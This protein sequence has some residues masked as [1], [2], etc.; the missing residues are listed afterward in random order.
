LESLWRDLNLG[1]KSIR[2]RDKST[3]LQLSLV[4]VFVY[5]I[6]RC[7][8]M[9]HLKAI[10]VGAGIA[11]LTT[12][13][14]L[15]QAGYTVEIY[16]KVSSLRPAGAGISLWSN[17]VK[18]LNRLGLGEQLASFGGTM[19]RMEYR[20][21]HDEPLSHIDLRP[22]IHQVGQRP[23]PVSRTDLQEMLLNA[24]GREQVQFQMRC[25]DV[26]ETDDTITAIFDNGY[27]ATGD[28]LVGADGIRSRVREYVLGEPIMPRYANYVNWNGI[29]DA[30]PGLCDADN[31]VIYVGQ[32][33]RAS[34]MPIGGDR[35]YYFFGA[36]MAKGTTVEPANRREELAEIFADWP[37][38]VQKLIQSLDP[39]H[40]NRLE[41]HD[42][43]PPKSLAKG[44]AVLIGDAAHATTPTLGQGGCQA[45]EDVEVL[46][47][48]LVT[49]NISVSDALQRYEHERK[50]RTASLVLKARQRTDTIYGK[51]PALTQEWYEQLKQESP[52]AVTGALA[53]VILGGP[54][55]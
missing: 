50:D 16:E 54:M 38:P 10:V 9:Y 15:K 34:M 17:G 14:A 32:G 39:L 3:C 23:Y 46:T 48:Y 11:G 30:Q 18:V 45:V 53:K 26:E 2:L 5:L 27:R 1:D 36:P 28:I 12:A 43:D 42:I 4:G 40:T 41:I 21:H 47:R 22:L 49:T 55:R 31:W 13:I 37:A 20:S 35:F 8:N 52:D 29:V 7:R 51:D 24:A 44:R 19:N 6:Y 33:K 25:I